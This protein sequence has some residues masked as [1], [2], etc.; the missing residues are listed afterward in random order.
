MYVK[1]MLGKLMY[2]MLP[3]DTVKMAVRRIGSGL[4]SYE[5]LALSKVGR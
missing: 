2:R 4:P 3:E 5:E 1:K